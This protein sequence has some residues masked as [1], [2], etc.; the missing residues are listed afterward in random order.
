MQD[1]SLKDYFS[2]QKRILMLVGVPLT[3]NF[4]THQRCYCYFLYGTLVVY[5][6]VMIPEF[7]KEKDF[8][9]RINDLMFGTGYIVG[10]LSKVNR[11]LFS[12][13]MMCSI[14]S[15]NKSVDISSQSWETEQ[16]FE[17]IS[18]W[19]FPTKFRT[20]RECRTNLD[21]WYCSFY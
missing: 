5:L 4:S 10:R 18:N 14:F 16:D 3:K 15:S 13:H 6:S 11:F 8:D 17:N 1:S 9:N 20:W 19:S 7:F 12:N 2:I 21:T